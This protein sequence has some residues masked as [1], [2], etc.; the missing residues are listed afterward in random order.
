VYGH[1]TSSSFI[2]HL[3]YYLCESFVFSL[4]RRFLG[5]IDTECLGTKVANESIA[6]TLDDKCENGAFS[7]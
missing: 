5:C 4:D 2:P 3:L 7:L 1:E 6:L